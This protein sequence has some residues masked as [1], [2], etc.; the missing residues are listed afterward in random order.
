ML[1]A[2]F[3][4][5]G[6]TFSIEDIDRPKV[7]PQDVLIE[8]KAAS[9]CGTDVAYYN[10]ASTPRDLPATLGHE[11][12]GVIAEVGD[13][14]TDLSVGDRVIPH[15]IISC[16]KCKP[17]LQGN[18]NR[19]RERETRGAEGEGTFAEYM[20]LPAENAMKITDTVPFDWASIAAC[21]VATSYHA[22]KRSELR[23]GDT[24]VIF[25][26]GGVG[27][28]A[29]M[30]ANF[31]GAGSVIAVDL[32]DSK[33]DAAREYGA[34][35]VVNP[36]NGDDLREVIDEV[37]NGY[38]VDVALECSGSPKAMEQA[39]DAITGKNIHET[40][41]AVSVGGQH[42]PFDA[43]YWGLREGVL[44]VS[45]DH[46]HYDLYQI[47]ELLEGEKVDLSKSISHHISLDEINEGIEMVDQSE[48][49]RRVVIEF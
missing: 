27:H 23:N 15:Y 17:C 9:I 33:L 14:V 28:H 13:N 39:L 45:G 34:D 20:R 25:G 19:C 4:E 37:T 8:M 32:V 2:R 10:G 36:A 11:G 24:V 48:G 44:T 38:G 18:D 30:W 42:E 22:V 1:A 29:V 43:S 16:G 49:V 46:T 40:G 21:A 26:I 3:S 31:F 47:I 35:H 5:E 12:A 6:G 41:V 7:G